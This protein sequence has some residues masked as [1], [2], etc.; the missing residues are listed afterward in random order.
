MS[1]GDENP[2]FYQKLSLDDY[3]SCDDN[4]KSTFKAQNKFE[5]EKSGNKDDLI[6]LSPNPCSD[7]LLVQNYLGDDLLKI[8][9][10]DLL[11]ELKKQ[12]NING[13]NP[14]RILVSD[15]KSGPYVAKLYDS[16]NNVIVKKI[17]KQ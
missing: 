11:G 17:L 10:F 1:P 9:I 12:I 7:E 6:I 2:I 13:K 14:Y 5:G 15:L 8:E 16:N 4:L 3:P